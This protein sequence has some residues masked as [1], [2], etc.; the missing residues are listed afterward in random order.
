MRG[1]DSEF[2]QLLSRLRTPHKRPNLLLAPSYKRGAYDS[3]AIDCPFVF[4]HDG[5][6]YMT[7]I[8]WDGAGYRTGLASSVIWFTGAAGA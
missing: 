8:G 2:A 6:F 1:L 4:S 7:H 5:R 3:H